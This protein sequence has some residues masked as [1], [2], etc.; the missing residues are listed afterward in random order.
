M[1]LPPV[2]GIAGRARSGKSTAAALLVEVVLPHLSPVEDAQ[3]IGF[4]DPL[5]AAATAMLGGVNATSDAFKTTEVMPGITGRELL[6]VLGTE[7]VRQLDPDFWVILGM[8]RVR[9]CEFTIFHDVRFPN[10]AIAIRKAGGFIVETTRTPAGAIDGAAH[11]SEVPLPLG[12]VDYQL[13]N[14][15]DRASTRAHL[16]QVLQWGGYVPYD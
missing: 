5:K 14:T 1:K 16:K 6:Q 12:L 11:A 2:V 7:I 10:E 15:G 13:D 3:I 4:A 8:R 9:A